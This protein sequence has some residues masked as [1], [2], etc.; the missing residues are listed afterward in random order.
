[1]WPWTQNRVKNLIDIV[2][3]ICDLQKVLIKFRAGRLELKGNILYPCIGK[4]Y[5]EVIKIENTL[6]LRWV[7]LQ[8]NI[9]EQVKHI[10]KFRLTSFSTL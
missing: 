1:M 6:H 8:T 10:R 2:F 3:N 7:D 4:G 9:I 5:I